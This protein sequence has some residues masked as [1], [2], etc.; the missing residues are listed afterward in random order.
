MCR[1]RILLLALLFASPASAD[2]APFSAVIAE[3]EKIQA[4]NGMR[5]SSIGFGVI[6]LDP[7]APAQAVGYRIDSA[8]IPAS[9][10]KLVTTATA[11][12]MLGPDFRFQTELQHTGA[13]SEDG[14]LEGDVI[15]KG[16]G[17]PTLGTSRISETFAPWQ[18]A[19]AKAGIKK[20]EGRIIGD[21]SI[22]GT[23]L[24]ADSWQW[25]DLGNYYAAGACGL[26]FH[27]NLFYA[28]FRTPK[29][30]ASASLLGTDPKLPQA[31]FVTERRVG[32][33][34]SG[35]DG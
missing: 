8:M 26:T 22:F 11:L 33:A 30:G 24:R 21:A 4:E 23:Q 9:T 17:D 20:I 27:Q 29:A 34:G 13:I 28:T 15:I 2:P 3:V 25:N 6:A 32:P 7:E 18:T 5:A 16:G 12:E 1:A 14:T 19:L 31:Q 35:D 10:L